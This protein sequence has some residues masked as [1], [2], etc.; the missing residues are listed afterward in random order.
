MLS[1]IKNR[2]RRA[3]DEIEGKYLVYSLACPVDKKVRWIGI[4]TWLPGRFESH[5]NNFDS[6]NILK[7]GWVLAL[8]KMGSFPDMKALKGFDEREDAI[9]YENHLILKHI[10]TVLN[11]YPIK[12]T[13]II[14]RNGN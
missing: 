11:K 12:T 10:K 4:S 3:H 14:L 8:K 6:H 13:G 1:E 5:W 2:L 7:T 9:K